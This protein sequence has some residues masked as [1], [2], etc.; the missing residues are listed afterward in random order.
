MSW[1]FASKLRQSD[2]GFIF[3]W[4]EK[5]LEPCEAALNSEVGEF[6]PLKTIKNNADEAL[7]SLPK[8]LPR[9]I[10]HLDGR[11]KD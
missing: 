10:F 5:S 7:K 1:K 9:S 8:V 6:T 4:G 3:L 2:R 11:G